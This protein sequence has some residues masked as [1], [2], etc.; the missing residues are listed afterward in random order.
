MSR[1]L[2]RAGFAAA[3]IVLLAATQWPQAARPQKNA[4]KK[5]AVA[6]GLLERG[7]YL[8]TVTGCHDCHS[9]KVFTERG[10]EP[11]AKRLLSG[12][13][14][15]D[16]L[17][18]VPAGLFGPQGWGG[19]TNQ[20][21][22]AWVG[23]WG[24]S[25]AV[26][27]TPDDDTGLGTWNEKMFIQALRT[28]QHMGTGRPILPPMPWPALKHLSDEDLLAMFAY[29][30]SLPPVSNRVPEPLPPPGAPK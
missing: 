1:N 26:N 4:D 15:G 27:L 6:Q 18:A 2:R 12:H 21:L 7:Q 11:D 3:A 17:P 16:V 24:T 25:F 8:V 22:T 29:L 13:P 5:Q 19:L 9:P 14:A 28:G 23:P 10:P 20:H 30:Q